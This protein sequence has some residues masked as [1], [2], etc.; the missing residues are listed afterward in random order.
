MAVV[1]L[2][3]NLVISKFHPKYSTETVFSVMFG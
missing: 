1:S 3:K 2:V